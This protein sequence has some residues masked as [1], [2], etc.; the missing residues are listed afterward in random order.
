MGGIDASKNNGIPANPSN[1]NESS[2]FALVLMVL[3]GATAL[4]GF[5]MGATAIKFIG[6]LL[7]VGASIEIVFAFRDRSFANSALKFLFGGMGLLLGV[8]IVWT[9]LESLA[10]LMLLLIAFLFANGVVEIVLSMKL[11]PD[12]NWG[13]LLFSG[14]VSLLLSSLVVIEQ[15]LGAV[16]A[17]GV[18]IGI[19]MA[20][21][22]WVLMGIEKSGRIKREI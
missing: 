16:Q 17:L 11:R 13:W 14:L 12:K 9:P 15:P 3:G 22:G 4:V 20:I 6:T 1:F 2:G 8:V 18:Y 21:H 10:Q 7:L 5:Y 19:V